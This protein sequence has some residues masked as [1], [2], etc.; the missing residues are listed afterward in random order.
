ML[1]SLPTDCRI[2]PIKD[3]N[4]PQAHG[5][6]ATAVALESVK[7]VACHS[8]GEHALSRRPTAHKV[9]KQS[10]ALDPHHHLCLERRWGLER[11]TWSSAGGDGELKGRWA[12]PG[13]H[14]SLASSDRFA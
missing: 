10:G 6:G 1:A 3:V 5:D 14:W 12:G 4:W 9:F 2:F 7:R 8:D 13:R 11:V